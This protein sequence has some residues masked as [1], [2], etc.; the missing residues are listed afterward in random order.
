MIEKITS[1]LLPKHIR[2]PNPQIYRSNN[3]VCLD[4]ETTNLDHGSA[5]EPDNRLILST[6]SVG[7]E[8]RAYTE[9]AGVCYEYSDKLPEGLRAAIECADF[10]VCQNAKFEIQWLEREGVDTRHTVWYD[11]FLGEF[12][13]L[14]N[15]RGPK[16]LDSIAKRYGLQ[17]K[18]SVVKKLMAGGVC[19]SEIPKQW[20]IDYGCGDT[21]VTEQVFL[22]QRAELQALGLLPCLYTRC[23]VTPV[24]ADIEK[25]GMFLDK[26]RVYEEYN[27]SRN[28]QEEAE[29]SLVSRYTGINFSSSKQLGELLFVTLGFDEPVRADGSPDRTAGGKRRTDAECINSLKPRT[30]AQREFQ[31]LIRAHRKATTE[32]AFLSKLKECCDNEKSP[33]IKAQYNQA[34]AQN[35]RLTSNGRRYKIQLHNTARKYKRLFKARHTGWFCGEADGAQL[36]FRAAA[37]LGNDPVAL[38]DIR[39]HVDVHINTASV[40]EHK[41]PEKITKD[42][43]QEWKPET[44]RPLYGSKGQTPDQKKYAKFFHNRY[45]ATFKTQEGWTY[46]VLKN[47]KLVT[48]WGLIFY[49]PDT[50][51][52]QSGYIKNT[53]NIYNYPVSSLATAE[54]IPITL[55]YTWHYM[56]ALKMMSFLN[57]TIH[58]SVE[59]EIAPHERETWTAI[60]E[61]TFTYDVFEYCRKVYNMEI[62][63]PLGT[64]IKYGI[65]W[66]EAQGGESKYEVDPKTLN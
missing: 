57:N 39:E 15:R 40:F 1:E 66:S 38:G 23:L 16:D 26:E 56:R 63:V 6:W 50:K 32:L 44:F 10:C 27:S 29:R 58:D 37:H 35:H 13:R 41:R 55:V 60:C 33:I 18:S 52:S 34:I 4:F 48:P 31:E 21:Y 8:H 49:W 36:E 2:N 22:R 28:K 25:Y 3:Y 54:W 5:L 42:Q 19:P 45:N 61:Q 20:L 7:R 12:V 62:L 14:G 30:E 59:G 43:R 11:T 53:T 24:L 47:K 17:G 9:R 65:N 46:E 64:E 51:M